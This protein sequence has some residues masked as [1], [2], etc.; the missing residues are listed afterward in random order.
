MKSYENELLSKAITSGGVEKLIAQ[1]LEPRHF[2]TDKGKEIWTFL[3]LHV[4]K[5]K[6]S[7][8]PQ[9]VKEQFPKFSW[10]VVTEPLEYISDRF[11]A[12]V[13]RKKAVE[14][15]DDV[16]QIIDKDDYEE[17]AVIDEIFLDKAKELAQELPSTAASKFSGANQ[18]I[19]SYRERKEEGIKIGKS[20]GIDEL[21][22]WT[23]GLHPH[24]YVTIAGFTGIGKST[25]GLQLAVNHYIEGHT[26]MIISLEMDED[27]IYRKLDGIAA[28]LRQ[29][30]LRELTLSGAE[31]ER[32]EQV[33]ERAQTAANDIIIVD[34]DFATPEKVYAETS[35][36]NPDMVFVDYVQLLL[37]P[38]D[39]RATWEKVD[40]CS[41]MLKSQ[42]RAMKIPVYG[43]A[44]TNADAADEGA[45]LTNLGGSKAIGF[46]S[47]LM[48]GLKQNPEDAAEN[49]M[50]LMIEKNRS[51]PAGKIIN[52]YWNHTESEYR[53][54]NSKTDAYARG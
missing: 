33:A 47:D 51:G 1:G 41:R 21:D 15:F 24:Q 48:L 28:S 43:L 16:A 42:A 50:L 54:W 40:Y 27:E 52:L 34:T 13:K 8:D 38:R 11:I 45:K 4:N 35:R 20:F 29:N 3:T 10:E 17:I 2:S 49:K 26:P 31:I 36:W 9:T 12:Q 44:Q 37:A 53:Q 23:L 7:P 6:S 46:H 18:R 5:Y 22:K 39:Y 14:V 25:L 30:A 19:A 32:W